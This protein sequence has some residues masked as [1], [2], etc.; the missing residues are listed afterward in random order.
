MKKQEWS[1]KEDNE[2]SITIFDGMGQERAMIIECDEE[3]QG[4][5]GE[6]HHATAKLI[7]DAVNSF[8]KKKK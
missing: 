6:R 7:C 5:I 4:N 3:G 1:Y 8:L 2:A